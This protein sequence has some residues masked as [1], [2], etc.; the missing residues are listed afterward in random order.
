MTDFTAEKEDKKKD[1]T[2]SQ[3][4]K[5]KPIVWLTFTKLELK[6]EFN[7][8]ELNKLEFKALNQKLDKLTFMMKPL[9]LSS[10]LSLTSFSVKRPKL[11]VMGARLSPIAPIFAGY[12][13]PYHWYFKKK[14][15]N[16]KSLIRQLTTNS[17][18]TNSKLSNSKLSNFSITRSLIT[19]SS[20]KQE[21]GKQASTQQAA[22]KQEGIQLASTKLASTKQF[23]ITKLALTNREH[24]QFNKLNQQTNKTVNLGNYHTDI[25]TY[26]QN[27]NQNQNYNHQQNQYQSLVQHHF[28]KQSFNRYVTNYFDALTQITHQSLPEIL[29]SKNS[30]WSGDNFPEN[31]LANNELANNELANNELANNELANNELANNELALKELSG[32]KSP[33][34]TLNMKVSTLPYSSF[35]TVKSHLLINKKANFLLSLLRS[36]VVRSPILLSSLKLQSQLKTNESIEVGREKFY[37]LLAKFKQHCI[38]KIT[39]HTLNERLNKEISK[40][41]SKE[42]SIGSHKAIRNRL[43]NKGLAAYLISWS[44]YK[45]NSYRSNFQGKEVPESSTESSTSILPRPL[46]DKSKSTSSVQFQLFKLSET[47]TNKRQGDSIIDLTQEKP[48]VLTLLSERLSQLS[49]I[50]KLNLVVNSE[51]QQQIFH[52]RSVKPKVSFINKSFF[53]GLT[54]KLSERINKGSGEYLKTNHQNNKINSHSLNLQTKED[55]DSSTGTSAGTSVSSPSNNSIVQSILFK[56]SEKRSNKRSGDLAVELTQE[57]PLALTSVFQS[58]KLLNNTVKKSA[59]K[60][61]A[62]K[63]QVVKKSDVNKATHKQKFQQQS[64]QFIH[65]FTDGIIFQSL[66]QGLK[67]GAK[68]GAINQLTKVLTTKLTHWAKNR[69]NRQSL[70]WHD[71]DQLNSMFTTS[72]SKNNPRSSVH[73]LSMSR[74]PI[75]R[76][77]ISRLPN[78]V[79]NQI[80]LSVEQLNERLPVLASLFK[81]SNPL[82][83]NITLEVNPQKLTQQAL[84]LQPYPQDKSFTAKNLKEKSLKTDIII[85]DRLSSELNR[86]L[87]RELSREPTSEQITRELFTREQGNKRFNELNKGFNNI[88]LPK[89]MSLSKN[90]INRH[91]LIRRDKTLANSSSG[92]LANKNTLQSLFFKLSDKNKKHSQGVLPAELL[93]S[94]L[95]KSKS[96]VVTSSFKKLCK[97]LCEKSFKTLNQDVINIKSQLTPVVNAAVNKQKRN[98]SENNFNSLDLKWRGKELPDSSA[99][100]FMG[101]IG[102]VIDGA[103]GGATNESISRVCVEKFT[104][105]TIT[106]KKTNQSVSPTQ[107]AKKQR[108]DLTSTLNSS[109]FNSATQLKLIEKSKPGKNTFKLLHNKV[110]KKLQQPYIDQIVFHNLNK[111]SKSNKFREL[112]KVTSSEF[113]K[114]LEAHFISSSNNNSNVNQLTSAKLI[115]NQLNSNTLNSKR[116]NKS[117]DRFS[118]I[119]AN[120][121]PINILDSIIENSSVHNFSTKLFSHINKN[122]Y[123]KNG[124]KYRK[125]KSRNKNNHKIQSNNNSPLVL[126]VNSAKKIRTLLAPSTDLIFESSYEKIAKSDRITSKN[127]SFERLSSDSLSSDLNNKEELTQNQQHHERFAQGKQDYSLLLSRMA[128]KNQKTR[129]EL[130]AVSAF[131]LPAQTSAVSKTFTVNEQKLNDLAHHMNDQLKQAVER[132]TEQLVQY[133]EQDKQQ[134]SEQ[135]QKLLRAIAQQG[136]QFVKQQTM[137]KNAAVSQLRHYIAPPSFFDPI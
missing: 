115:S 71:N 46:S 70:T 118:I 133:R 11:T 74:P 2:N 37:P 30:Q 75:P 56:R 123:S 43:T 52:Q 61:Q 81:P 15:A 92:K 87:N 90:N 101:T 116:G 98:W 93:E 59:V 7:K 28:Y 128:N 44:K 94:Q 137:P 18:I 91:P 35:N 16:K 80:V 5:A 79:N 22:I 63:E 48:L 51:A 13:L 49:Q 40:E 103:I 88:I 86:E 65:N 26:N 4:I 25:D 82:K 136:Q 131:G 55:P 67:N 117:A 113:N 72:V 110:H 122:N 54:N 41:P 20:I 60:K 107:Q 14:D 105:K 84:K 34:K 32:S 17:F 57:Q 78:K 10:K 120:K 129:S 68:N 102:E 73:I 53:N 77:P 85:D 97:K 9:S 62:E 119:E 132:I 19:Q 6:L 112:R 8:L 47:N 42:L 124:N 99:V 58:V 31:K 108:P 109:I 127:L 45:I 76:P 33:D 121:L 114:G 111:L 38:D 1:E 66:K 50:S 95:A 134:N 21:P 130:S 27:Q 24:H 12:D 3:S 29:S 106:G 125:N 39:F 100:T 126:Q 36:S 89:I 135:Y 69:T 23:S 83:R 64:V 104:G 96:L